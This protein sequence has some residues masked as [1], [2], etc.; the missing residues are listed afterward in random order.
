MDKRTEDHEIVRAIVS[1]AGT[2]G[3][4]TVA[5]GVENAEQRTRLVQLGCD[6]GQGYLF[7]RPVEAD[8]AFAVRE[9][10]AD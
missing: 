7:G 10:R 4:K 8:E 2:L 6:L 3:L 5:E 9:R 1:L